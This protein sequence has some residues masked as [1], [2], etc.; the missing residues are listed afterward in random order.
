ML[1]NGDYKLL[2][3]R[4]GEEGKATSLMQDHACNHIS[5]EYFLE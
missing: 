4:L 2:K 5:K 1:Y 3:L